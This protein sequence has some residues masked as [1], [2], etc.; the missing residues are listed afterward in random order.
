MKNT[1]APKVPSSPQFDARTAYKVFSGDE[2]S[3]WPAD[4]AGQART[5][6]SLSE[7]LGTFIDTTNSAYRNPYPLKVASVFAAAISLIVKDSYGLSVAT[8]ASTYVE[9]L[10]TE[11]SYEKGI[12]GGSLYS[13]IPTDGMGKYI[14]DYW[15]HLQAAPK[16]I[17][18]ETSSILSLAQTA[19]SNLVS[20]LSK[21]PK[22]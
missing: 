8:A 20:A 16:Y 1:S 2:A 19:K 17:G 9:Y 3:G 7:D 4:D 18:F 6:R 11:I 12:N 15:S 10:S 14:T 21:L 22:C 13:P 5:L